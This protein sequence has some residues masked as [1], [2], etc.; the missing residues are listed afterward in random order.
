MGSE[1]AE[2]AARLGA[3][4]TGLVDVADIVFRTEFRKLCE[5]NRCGSYGRGWMCPPAVGDIEVLIGEV[6]RRSRALVFTTVSRL[7]GSYDWRGMMA[8][9]ERFGRLVSGISVEAGRALAGRD[10]LVLGAGPCKVC[11]ECAHRISEPCRHPDRA[12]MSLEAN[13]V[14]VSQLAKLT[15]LKYNNGPG[16]VTYFGAIF[17]NP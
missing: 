14:D 15:G 7:S 3:G 13:G 5:A 1:V 4:P 11:P 8:A 12:V 16:T 10:A 9:G 17:F 6:R 2:L